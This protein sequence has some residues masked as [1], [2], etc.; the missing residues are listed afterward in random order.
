[1]LRAVGVTT[2]VR[3]VTTDPEAEQQRLRKAARDAAFVQATSVLLWVTDPYGHLLEDSPTWRAFTGLSFDDV[4]TPWGWAKALHPDDR[5]RV[6][7]AWSRAV[8]SKSLFVCEQRFRRWDGTYVW[9]LARAAPVLDERGDIVEWVGTNMD[10]S[11][12]KRAE[13]E[14]EARLRVAEQFIGILGHDLRNPIN[15]IQMAAQLLERKGE[16]AGDRLRLVERIAASTSRMSNMVAQLL[17]LT[18]VRLGTGLRV[19]RKATNL[20]QVVTAAVEELR[21]V[22]PMRIV[23]CACEAA[24]QG[25]W[26]VDRLAQVVSN[27]VGN[28]LQHGD[29]ARPVEVRLATVEY[30]AVFEVQSYGPPIPPELLPH[31]FDPYRQGQPCRGKSQGLGLGL[32]ITQEI[33]HAHGGRIDVRST[34]AEGTRFIVTL[35]RG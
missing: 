4:M 22:Y 3:E 12:S 13:E 30:G 14:R 27:L 5:E 17:N 21:L 8:R 1:M 28:A 15:A 31:I 6:S 20:S 35:P 29:P 7:A 34:A 26:D 18:R 23:E 9:T 33:V 10:I 11:E 16:S 19:E 24:V 32:F 25:S 2:H